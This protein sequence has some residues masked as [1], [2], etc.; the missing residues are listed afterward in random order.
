MAIVLSL[1]SFRGFDDDKGWAGDDVVGLE[2][3]IGGGFRYEVILRLCEVR[4]QF[5]AI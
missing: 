5:A 3:A 4:R 1:N 2:Q